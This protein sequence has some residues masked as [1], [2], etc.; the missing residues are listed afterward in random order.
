MTRDYGRPDY[1]DA[2]GPA[3]HACQD[4]GITT[5]GYCVCDAGEDRWRETPEGHDHA[6]HTHPCKGCLA[7]V[8]CWGEWRPN[9]DGF[10]PEVC[11]A[12]HRPGGVVEESWCAG[13]RP[14]GAHHDAA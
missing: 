11:S 3:C 1:F 5:Q 13:C 10:P 7:P 6:D 9:P 12:R 2:G 8:A 14:K 4:T